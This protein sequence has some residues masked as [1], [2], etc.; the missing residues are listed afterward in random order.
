MAFMRGET[1]DPGVVHAKRG[2]IQFSTAPP[3]LF[4]DLQTSEEQNL[5]DI[6]GPLGAS[7]TALVD[8]PFTRPNVPWLNRPAVA[9]LAYDQLSVI[10]TQRPLVSSMEEFKQHLNRAVATDIVDD[11]EL[12]TYLVSAT[13][14]VDGGVTGDEAVLISCMFA[15]AGCDLIDVSTGQTVPEAKPI[16]GRMYQTPFSDQI[17]NNGGIAT[18]CV[19]AITWIHPVQSRRCV[20]PTMRWSWTPAR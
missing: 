1:D 3:P 15:E 2:G 17:R 16:Y 14:W 13:D 9:V 11:P 8:N 18:M 19:G 10:A 6:I 12:R 20:W 4:D 7:A 5:R